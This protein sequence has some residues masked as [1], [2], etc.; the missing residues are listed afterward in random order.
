MAHDGMLT[1][2][3][4]LED[5]AS[6]Y[7]DYHK[8]TYGFR[9]RHTKGWTLEDYE[10]ETEALR[11][12]YAATVQAER[13]AEAAAVL[14]LEQRIVKLIGLGAADRAAAIRW[15]HEAEETGGD[16][17]YLCFTLG[18]PYGYFGRQLIAA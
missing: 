2:L 1:E 17:Q 9:P 10:R 8:D 14:E 11:P 7:S 4:P 5:A 6:F 15:I 3:T 18:V 12:I 13:V 16:D